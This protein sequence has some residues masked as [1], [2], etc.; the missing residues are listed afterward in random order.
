VVLLWLE[1]MSGVVRLMVR[2]TSAEG[3]A[4]AVDAGEAARW[5]PAEM[6][7][8]GAGDAA[9]PAMAFGRASSPAGDRVVVTWSEGGLVYVAA[10]D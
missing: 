9:V 2:T 1:E 7:S 10:I 6:L 3:S 5:S 4:A 8:Q